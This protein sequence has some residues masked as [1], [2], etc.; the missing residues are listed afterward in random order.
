MKKLKLELVVLYQKGDNIA[1]ISIGHIGNMINDI[2]KELQE[3]NI[4]IG[5]YDVRFLK[6][7]DEKLLHIIFQKYNYIVT[8][9]DGCLKGG[10]GSAILEFSNDNNYKN[11]IFRFGVPDKFIE[12]GSPQEQR[13]ECGYDKNKRCQKNTRNYK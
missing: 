11:N 2:N 6:P 9:E 3:S 7:L 12:H 8:I 13:I 10:L 5:H 4:K 1:V